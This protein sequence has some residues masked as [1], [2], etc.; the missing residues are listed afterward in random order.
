MVHADR[1]TSMSGNTVAGLLSGL[2]VTRS[3][4]RPN[5]S[6]DQP[7]F[8]TPKCAST[9]PKRFESIYHAS[10]FVDGLA[11]WH[12]HEHRHRGS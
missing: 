5:V 9:F 8:K 1:G 10:D 7:W 4:S 12:H 2:G 11:A 3:H 6:N